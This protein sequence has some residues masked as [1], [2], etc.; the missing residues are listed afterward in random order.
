[1]GDLPGFYVCSILWDNPMDGG[2]SGFLQGS[3][4]DE[5]GFK[6]VSGTFADCGVPAVEHPDHGNA[7]PPVNTGLICIVYNAT[8][9]TTS[10]RC[11]TVRLVVI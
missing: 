4:G 5:L 8:C 6:L 10:K 2:F 3:G 9:L 1:M 11:N 7:G